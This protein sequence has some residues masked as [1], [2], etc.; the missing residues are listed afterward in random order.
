MAKK[1][2]SIYD[3]SVEQLMTLDNIVLDDVE[4]VA[5]LSFSRQ[6]RF[7]LG[8]Y[9]VKELTILYN[10]YFGNCNILRENGLIEQ[11]NKLKEE[12][13]NKNLVGLIIV[14]LNTDD[15]LIDKYVTLNQDIITLTVKSISVYLIR[16]YFTKEE[17]DN[18]CKKTHN[19]E[20]YCK[21]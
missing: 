3:M 21:N 5:K 1:Y 12:V 7:I 16:V 11:Y 18:L 2:V 8:F 4:E 10:K 9:C 20:L 17:L 13:V 15:V 19:Y 6:E 14:G